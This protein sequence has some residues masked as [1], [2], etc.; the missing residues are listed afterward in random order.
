M[1]DRCSSVH[2]SIFM[3]LLAEPGSPAMTSGV[4]TPRWP[5]PRWIEWAVG[6]KVV[7]LSVD[8]VCLDPGRR[9]DAPFN[10]V[11][12]GLIGMRLR[13]LRCL[14]QAT[15]C[16]GCPETARCDYAS[17]F[18]RRLMANESDSEGD[19]VPPFWLQG[20]PAGRALARG[21]QLS[22]RLHVTG[23]A[24]D[25]L[26]Y[27][28]VACR[29]ALVHV[30]IR[31]SAS[32]VHSTDLRTSKTKGGRIM[33]SNAVKYAAAAA[34]STPR[35]ISSESTPAS[36]SSAPSRCMAARSISGATSGWLRA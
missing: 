11:V 14:T 35:S 28:D 26:P 4:G 21:V 3:A 23:Q 32:A 17:V 29:D 22:I 2:T 16:A 31:P 9:H 15:T 36:R 12:R 30:G 33:R 10:T 1:H 6:F 18:A 34:P 5:V 27:L 24:V 13:D 7:S 20:L 8:A 19:E 25:A